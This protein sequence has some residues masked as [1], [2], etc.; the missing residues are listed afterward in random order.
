MPGNLAPTI[1]AEEVG[2][3]RVGGTGGGK[4]GEQDRLE[5]ALRGMEQAL[6]PLGLRRSPGAPTL[7][8]DDGS[9]DQTQ[10]ALLA[11]Q[12]GERPWNDIR[13]RFPERFQEQ[14]SLVEFLRRR[15]A[16]CL[17]RKPAVHAISAA[18]TL[19]VAAVLWEVCSQKQ[20]GVE[21]SSQVSSSPLP[22]PKDVPAQEEKQDS[23][24]EDH[25]LRSS[26]KERL[27][28]FGFKEGVLTFDDVAIDLTDSERV[29]R[30]STTSDHTVW[31]TRAPS[32]EVIN[33]K[34]QETITIPSLVVFRGEKLFIGTPTR[35]FAMVDLPAGEVRCRS[36]LQEE[37]YDGQ[38]VNGELHKRACKD[39]YMSL[40]PGIVA[41]C[42]DLKLTPYEDLHTPPITEGEHTE[43]RFY[44]SDLLQDVFKDAYEKYLL[45]SQLPKQ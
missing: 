44:M 13:E 2:E 41:L 11:K 17:R 19:A 27:E 40:G 24:G 14:S 4:E 28:K 3:E 18:A 31:M 20:G 36:I 39:T 12:V 6:L 26:L 34:T 22:A 43:L 29:H 9:I 5:M 15:T 21:G 35:Y 10:A 8:R 25:H 23:L 16:E 38:S 7:Y 30:I 42:H 45:F 1:T 32:I 37:G 33:P